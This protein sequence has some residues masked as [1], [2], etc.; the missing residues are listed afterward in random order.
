MPHYERHFFICTNGPF[1]WYDGDSDA[2]LEAFKK[3]AA[4]AGLKDSVRFNRSGC[5]NA[6]GHG[7]VIVVYP[8]DI[9]YGH[10]TID[11]VPEIFHEH[12]LQGR[13]VA[14]LRLA[15]EA[16]KTTDHYPEPV[17]HFKRVERG[18]DDQRIA[19]REAIFTLLR[20]Q[21]EAAEGELAAQDTVEVAGVRESHIR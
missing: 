11:D 12:V 4:G 21:R 3:R 19:A 20:A 8:E 2:I 1:C 17:Q 18:L 16:T 14:R 7:P 13:P 10:V 9:W 15:P 6:C 5:L